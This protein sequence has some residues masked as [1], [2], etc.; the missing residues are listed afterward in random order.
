M[1]VPVRLTVA[2]A[3]SA[4][5]STVQRSA[6]VLCGVYIL[7]C[8][9][10]ATATAQ[11]TLPATLRAADFDQGVNGISYRDTSPG[12]SGGYY[13]VTDVD[14]EAC[15]EGGVNIGWAS[16]GE[17]LNYTVTVPKAGTYSL[18]VRVASSGGGRLN[19]QFAGSNKTG[20][21]SVPDTGGWQ[22]WTT[23][24]RTVTLS[25]GVQVMRVAFETDGIN[26]SS[27][28][29]GGSGTAS[30]ASSGG[31][32]F[33]GTV[34]AEN[35]DDGPN[36]STY[37]DST[38]GNSGGQARDTDV[39][40]EG[41][42]EGAYNVGWAAAGEWLNYTLNVQS[43]GSY[44]LN[45]RVASTRGGS[46]YVLFDGSNKT[47]SLRVPVTGGYQVW[48]TVSAPVNLAAGTQVM[49]VVFESGGV[50]LNW[51]GGISAGSATSTVSPASVSS[52]FGGSAAA[53]PGTI[54]AEAFDA[55]GSG[56]SYSDNTP[57]NSGG[58]YRSTDVDIES[59]GS[60]YAVAWIGAG[61][62]LQYTVNVAAA[63]NYVMTARVASAGSGGTFHVETKGQNR[64]AVR[65]PDTGWWGNY[66]DVVATVYLDAGVQQMRV[67]FDSNGS[68]GAVGNFD[69]LRFAQAIAAP[70]PA[71]APAPTPPT[72]GR[73]RVMTWNLNF[74]IDPAGQAQ[75]IAD[76]GADV[77]LLQEASLWDEDMRVTYPQRLQQLTGQKWYSVFA[78]HS[79]RYSPNEGTMI[80]SRLPLLDQSTRNAYDRGFS[81]ILVN[82][83]GVQVNL[84]NTHLDWADTNMRSL[85][86]EDFMWWARQFGGAKVAGGDFNSWWG[87]YWIGRMTSEYSDTWLDVTGS[88]ENGYTLN[89]SVRFD[90]LFHDTR[91][92]PWGA[93]VTP[94]SRSDHA[95][96]I[97][98][99][100]VR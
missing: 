24:K 16:G 5:W 2:V 56:V 83:G 17:W 98:D 12:N 32:T 27:I 78:S 41:S 76:S 62:W 79:G 57:G 48:T 75:V 7:L 39:D 28:A 45:L 31:R 35:F 95:P 60:E 52:P 19:V 10:P 71:P 97:A 99:Y 63:G 100:T 51:I 80:L 67:V 25:A 6:K 64:G 88:Q 69:F 42:T 43:S 29:I 13:R 58:A 65:V 90:Y 89:G 77:A 9:L 23:I 33:P 93:W 3:S 20:S 46:I 55:G 91:A 92:I 61:E 50:N 82:V 66:Q 22:S 74:G 86:L 81:R 73:L 15:A 70:A 26:L 30:S 72:G 38:A 8:G 34:E 37:W 44:T 4:I 1:K 18:E 54:Q 85:Q 53:V 49:R 68:A 40:I 36:G 11:T 47:G 14:I 87:E 96:L 94:T 21:M 59:G 84:L